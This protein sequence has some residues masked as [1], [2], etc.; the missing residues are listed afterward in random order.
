[1]NFCTIDF[2]TAN[3]SRNSACA[4]G[5]VKV[6]NGAI[7]KTFSTLIRPPTMG[8]TFTHIH[9]LTWQMVKDAP[10]FREIWPRIAEFAQGAEFIGA[11]NAPFDRSVLTA[12]LRDMGIEPTLPPFKCT[13]KLSKEKWD[14]P[15]YKLSDV[16]RHLNIAL[17]HHEAQSD[18]LGCAKILLAAS[19]KGL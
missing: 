6:E 3:Y 19:F 16:C 4:V 13:L 17:N 11:H 5:L 9:K 18:A 7:V 2:E 1:M 15:A 10:T 12:C 14:I 8:F